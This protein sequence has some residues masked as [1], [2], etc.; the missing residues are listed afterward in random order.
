MQVKL[1][2]QDITWILHVPAWNLASPWCTCDWCFRIMR[3][4]FG[5][6]I[7]GAVWTNEPQIIIIRTLGYACV[8]HGE[9]SVD[10]LSVF[11]INLLIDNFIDVYNTFGSHSSPFLASSYLHLPSLL[12]SSTKP[13]SYFPSFLVMFCV[14]TQLGL[15]GATGMGMDS[16]LSSG[17]EYVSKDND[18]LSGGYM[19]KDNDSFSPSVH[20]LLFHPPT[21]WETHETLPINECLWALSCAGLHRQSR[22]LSVHECLGHAM[23]IRECFTSQLHTLPVF[24]SSFPCSLSHGWVVWVSYLRVSTQ[25]SLVLS[26]F[27]QT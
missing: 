24:L 3:E 19:A 6:Q 26:T 17:C 15:A 2:E 20:R 9:Y 27:Y 18:F 14:V 12:P 8:K 11:K 22:L 5:M 4:L 10:V 7:L 1:A 23:S 25:Q 21:G 13:L 16:K